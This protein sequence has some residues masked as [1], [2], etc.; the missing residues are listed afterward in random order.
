MECKRAYSCPHSVKLGVVLLTLTLNHPPISAGHRPP[1]ISPPFWI[2]T[3]RPVPEMLLLIFLV[4]MPDTCRLTAT[5]GMTFWIKKK[6][7]LISAALPM[8]GAILLILSRHGAGKGKAAVRMWP[9]PISE[10]CTGWRSNSGKT[11]YRRKR[12]IDNAR[13]MPNRFWIAFMNG[14]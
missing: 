1:P 6:A 13:N 2:N 3:I 5:V 9:Y 7:C 11:T 10:N 4:S 14:S 8:P 12:F